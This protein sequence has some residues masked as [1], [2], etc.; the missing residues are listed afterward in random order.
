MGSHIYTVNFWLECFIQTLYPLNKTHFY[1]KVNRFCVS[2]TIT[3]ATF[4]AKF[5]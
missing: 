4:Q 2:D 5:I 3:Y 1:D